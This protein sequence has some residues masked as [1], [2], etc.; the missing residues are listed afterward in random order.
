MLGASPE[1]EDAVQE[2]FLR[3]WR[4]RA[5]YDGRSSVRSWLYRIATNTCLDSLARRRP[6]VLRDDI[7]EDVGPRS[8]GSDVEVLHRETIELTLLA[9]IQ[10]L[11]CKQRAVLMLRD[12]LDWSA[13]DTARLLDDSVPAV[14]SAL[15]RARATMKQRLAGQR[16]EWAPSESPNGH[17]RA[18]LRRFMHALDHGESGPLA[19]AVR[20]DLH[21]CLCPA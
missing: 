9:A 11:S 21:E 8:R 13:I 17:E 19:R 4:S 16:L 7:A 1:A 14:E 5:T 15:Q 20:D 12:L 3:A 10:H 6:D 2:T 18:T